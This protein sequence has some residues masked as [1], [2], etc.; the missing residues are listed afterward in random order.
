MKA[1][2]RKST[3]QLLFGSVLI[4]LVTLGLILLFKDLSRRSPGKSR[5]AWPTAQPAKP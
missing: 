5:I 3:G 1:S 2:P 4:L